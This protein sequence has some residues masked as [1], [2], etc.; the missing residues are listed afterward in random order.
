MGNGVGVGMVSPPESELSFANDSSEPF[1][2]K[3]SGRTPSTSICFFAIPLITIVAMF[4]LR[5]FLPIV[6]FLF[7]LWFLLLLRFCIPPSFSIS[8][9]MSAELD[10]DMDFELDADIDL[11]AELKAGFEPVLPPGAT[12]GDAVESALNALPADIATDIR[13]QL[14]QGQLTKE[15]A[16]QMILDLSSD[17]SQSVPSLEGMKAPETAFPRA[18]RSRELPDLQGQL[19]YYKR[20]RIREA[21]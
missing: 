16:A 3:A 9:D 6:V 14:Q 1:L 2:I 12:V 21:A 13:T 10:A 19:I 4:L 15:Q 20:V 8:A 17:F 18:E 11:S 5:L 7:Q